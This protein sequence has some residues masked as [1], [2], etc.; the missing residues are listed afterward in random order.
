MQRSVITSPTQYR[1]ALK[2]NKEKLQNNVLFHDLDPSIEIWSSD[3]YRFT[4]S[5]GDLPLIKKKNKKEMK[6]KLRSFF[7]KFFIQDI[8]IIFFLVQLFPDLPFLPIYPNVMFFFSLK[9]NATPKQE[10]QKQTAK[11]KTN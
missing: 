10:K 3:R 5:E 9:K 2:Q 8:L 6:Q 7:F 11:R 4:L 1:P